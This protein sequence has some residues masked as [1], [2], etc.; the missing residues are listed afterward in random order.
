MPEDSDLH[1]PSSTTPAQPAILMRLMDML[2]GETRLPDGCARVFGLDPSLVLWLMDT[3]ARSQRQRQL[4]TLEEALRMLSLEGLK[5]RLLL[6]SLDMLARRAH[7]TE[8]LQVWRQALRCACLCEALARELAYP[9]PHEA[10]LAGLLHNVG[11]LPPAGWDLDQ[12]LQERDAALAE[13]VEAW[14]YPSLLADALRY[15]HWPLQS[16]R[17]AAGI[18]QLLWSARSLAEQDG[19]ASET[20]IAQLLN[21]EAGRLHALMAEAYERAEG[22]L[23]EHLGGL[24]AISGMQEQ[25]LLLERSLARFCLLERFATAMAC[26]PQ[27]VEGVSLLAA[28][29]HE[30]HGLWS[31]ICLVQDPGRRRLVGRPL[32]DGSPPPALSIPLEGSDAAGAMAFAWNR[33]ILAMTVNQAGVSLLDIQLARL[34]GAEGVLAIPVG[35]E[36][37]EAV[38]LACGDR[39]RLVRLGEEQDY[40]ARLGRIAARPAQIRALPA[41]QPAEWHRRVRR[42]AHEI[43]NPLGIVKNYLALLRVKLGGDAAIADELRVIHEE[44]DRIARIVQDLVGERPQAS[45]SLPVDVNALLADLIKVAAAGPIEEKGVRIGQDFQADL[46]AL[47]CDPDKLRQLLLNLLL[48]AMEAAP[49]QGEVFLETHRIVNHRRERQ[50]EILIHNNGPEIPPEALAHLLR[51]W[52]TCSSPCPARRASRT[53]AWAWPSCATWRRTWGPVSPA[54]AIGAGPPSRYCY[55]SMRPLH[56]PGN[57]VRN[58]HLQ[59]RAAG[60]RCTDGRSRPSAARHPTGG[61]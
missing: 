12:L 49:E 2:G 20:E 25:P 21:L 1:P 15:Q 36:T 7:G 58:G 48:N 34:A 44:L 18:V 19:R 4:P 61:G 27:G 29:L 56:R 35:G 53:P 9:Q 26:R 42:L 41:G 46:P 51:P 31:P 24:P 55:R 52:P 13:L 43:N 28:H 17:D 37:P 10:Y 32:P 22:L 3:V 33:P 38:L 50:V 8:R 47:H 60:T 30:V 11:P 23:S 45:A 57:D 6:A 5:S 40:L 39:E 16:L 59:G 14:H 54:A